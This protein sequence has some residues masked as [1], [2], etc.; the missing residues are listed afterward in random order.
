MGSFRSRIAPVAKAALFN[1]GALTLLRAAVPSRLIGILR[2]H[3]IC[4]D[5]GYTYADPGIC[6]TPAGFERHVQHLARHYAVLPMPEVVERMRTH[7]PLPRNTV[8]ITF[9]DGYADNL[10]AARTLHRHGVSAT[11]FITAGCLAGGA[12]FWPSEVRALTLGLRTPVLELDVNGVKERIPTATEPERHA[13][14][15]RLNRLFKG[16]TIPVRE[17]LREQLRHAW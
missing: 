7:R 11:F 12:P 10:A 2:Y 16:N 3:A 14:V 9:D 4:G 17:H 1:S 15:R 8:V 13:A 6:V 5:E